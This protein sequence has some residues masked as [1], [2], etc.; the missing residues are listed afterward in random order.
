[1]DGL[2]IYSPMQADQWWIG[3]PMAISWN[4]D[5]LGGDVIVYLSRDGG[6]TYD[7]IAASTPNDG[8]F[9]WLVTGPASLNCALKIKP[10]NIKIKAIPN[11]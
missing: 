5:G 9:E 11:K 4:P 7:T 3:D 8:S 6:K 10:T 1:M 2:E